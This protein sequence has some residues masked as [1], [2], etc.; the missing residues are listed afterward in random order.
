MNGGHDLVQFWDVYL[1]AAVIIGVASMES[2]ISLA[3]SGL[4]GIK[5]IGLAPPPDVQPFQAGWEPRTFSK[6]SYTQ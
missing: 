3:A 2:R 1:V 6:M 5:D 4:L